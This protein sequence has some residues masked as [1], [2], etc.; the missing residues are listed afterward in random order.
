M[1]IRLLIFLYFFVYCLTTYSQDKIIDSLQIELSNSKTHDTLKL[2]AISTVMGE[3]YT[4]EEANYYYLN[5]ILEKLALKNYR[6]K[7]APELHNVYATYLAEAYSSSAIGEQ[8]KRNYVKAFSYID[9]SIALYKE[10]KS[11]ENMNFAIVTRGSLYSDIQEY[12]KAVQSLFVALKYFE[13]ANE[14]N[15]ANGVS[16]VQSYLGQIYLKQGKY[17][18]AIE[19]YEKAKNYYDQLKNN[20]PQDIHEQSYLYGNVGKCYFDL[21]RYPDAIANFEKSILLAKKIG[22]VV[23]VNMIMG[24]IA[25]VKIEQLKFEEAEK[26]LMEALKGDFNPVATTGNYI[27]LGRLYYNQKDFGKADYYLSKALTM[28][29]QY[30]QFELQQDAS[31]LL[32]KVSVANENYQKALNMYV[33]H[34]QLID[35]SKT[36]SSKNALIQQELRYNFDKK[37]LNLKLDAEHKTAVKNNWLIA[38]TSLIAVLLLGGFFYYRNIKQKQAIFVLE[39]NQI[40]QKLLITQMNPHFIFNSVHNIRSLINNHQNEEAVNYLD[41]FSKLTRQILENSNENYISLEEEVE[42]IENYL[43]IQ[44][45]LYDKKF[46]YTLQVED[47]IDVTSVFLPPM[48]AQPFIENAIKHGLSNTMDNGL[49]A[50]HFY[51]RDNKLFFEVIDNGKGFDPQKKVTNHKSLAM[52]ITKERLV[53]YTKNKDFVVHTDNLLNPDGKIK[54]AKV[55]FEIPYIYEN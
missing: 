37:E 33:F 34:D 14:E 23:T 38:L 28:A 5:N 52:T 45:L 20:T 12:E 39:K 27:I 46:N 42:M 54:G 9:K 25:R 15:S 53:T 7:N 44:Q 10:A 51:L 32:Y 6:K 13:A 3:N 4:L 1:K 17:D 30:K 2:Q 55:V 41:K 49:V 40:K 24:K 43:A 47:D 22:D 36:E 11:Y 48:L 29:K 26:I 18:K 19:Y 50:V 35:S 8:R 21:K 16:Y 31:E